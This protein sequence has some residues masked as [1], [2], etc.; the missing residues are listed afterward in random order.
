MFI[1]ITLI[2]I[3]AATLT[4]QG[5]K[6]AHLQEYDL[7]GEIPEILIVA[8]RPT[9]SEMRAIGV[10][11]EVVVNAS[12]IIK[13][14]NKDNTGMIPT[15]EVTAPRPSKEEMRAAGVMPEVLI[16]AKRYQP[17][18]VRVSQQAVK[19]EKGEKDV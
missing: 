6:S 2:T 12:G 17:D 14:Q 13:S 8:Q 7:I 5:L 4:P 3:L 16:T 15:I 18:N 10:M 9:E 19:P 11:P 1:I